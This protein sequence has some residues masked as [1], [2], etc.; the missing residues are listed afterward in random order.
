MENWKQFEMDPRAYSIRYYVPTPVRI[1][2]Q[3]SITTTTP[4][5][6][7][8]VGLAL[9]QAIVDYVIANYLVDDYGPSVFADKSA[10]VRCA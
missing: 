8:D 3:V 4:E 9:R 5:Y 2:V 7:S 1:R 10:A 6:S